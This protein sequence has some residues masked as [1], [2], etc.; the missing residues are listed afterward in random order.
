MIILHHHT[1]MQSNSN[2]IYLLVDNYDACANEL[3]DDRPDP[4]QWSEPEHICLL[5]S[6]F[7]C[8]KECKTRYG[9]SKVYITGVRPLILQ[10]FLSGANDHENVSFEP[11]MSTICGLARSDVLGALRVMCNNEEEVQ[12][13]FRELE[14]RAGG[15]HFCPEQNVE[16][17][18]HTETALSYL[19][20]SKAKC[21]SNHA[22]CLATQSVKHRDDERPKFDVPELFFRACSLAPSAIEY[23]QRAL[24]KDEN[25]SYQKIRCYQSL[26]SFHLSPL[27]SSVK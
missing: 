9:V 3:M 25:G 17:V 21:M 10:D 12:K 26:S 22:D 1:I 6:F 11:Q 8:V 5:K 19:Q 24:Q 27:V 23:M 14:D 15:Y 13:H 7:G 16:P 2:E 18:S 4:R 20:V